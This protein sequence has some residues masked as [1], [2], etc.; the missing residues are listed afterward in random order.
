MNAE[1]R[2]DYGWKELEAI[3]EELEK[4]IEHQLLIKKFLKKLLDVLKE[5]Q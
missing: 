5:P 2:L 1:E 4:N 3:Y